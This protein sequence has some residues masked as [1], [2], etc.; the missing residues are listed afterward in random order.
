VDVAS[1][2]R[3]MITSFPFVRRDQPSV[4]LTPTQPVAVGGPI[5][6]NK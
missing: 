5:G 4:P 3:V 1:K 6:H 2:R